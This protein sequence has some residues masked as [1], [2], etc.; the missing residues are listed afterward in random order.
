MYL[1][2]EENGTVREPIPTGVE[3]SAQ[4]YI[5]ARLLDEQTPDGKLDLI[6]K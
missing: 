3:T 1:C 4:T 5:R 2:A 6:V